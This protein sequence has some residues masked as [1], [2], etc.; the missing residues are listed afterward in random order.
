[1]KRWV[2]SF[3]AGEV[4][5]AALQNPVNMNREYIGGQGEYAFALA[6]DELGAFVR[7]K[8]M[9]KEQGQ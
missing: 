1:M 2:V 8:Q 4:W 3:K 7:A 6:V 9:I 5:L